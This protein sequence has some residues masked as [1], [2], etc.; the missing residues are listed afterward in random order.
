MKSILNQIQW[1]ISFKGRINRAPLWWTLLAMFII[2]FIGGMIF[3]IIPPLVIVFELYLDIWVISLVAR[4]CHD[5]G[6]SGWW[7]ICPIYN[8]IVGFIE[9]QPGENQWGPNPLEVSSQV[10]ENSDKTTHDSNEQMKSF[11]EH[12]ASTS[13]SPVISGRQHESFPFKRFGK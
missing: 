3:A 5:I 1:N 11:P 9:S 7:S 4:R 12:Q 8:I 6:Q 2:A 10:S 13:P